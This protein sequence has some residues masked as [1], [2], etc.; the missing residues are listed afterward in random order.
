MHKCGETLSM[1]FQQYRRHKCGSCGCI[2]VCEIC[3]GVDLYNHP[4]DPV[5]FC[6]EKCRESYGKNRVPIVLSTQGID[7]KTGKRLQGHG[8]GGGP[9]R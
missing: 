8:P 4:S 2:F 5:Y 3:C 1:M 7:V 9:S 6:S